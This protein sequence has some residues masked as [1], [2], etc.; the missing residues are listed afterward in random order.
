MSSETTEMDDLELTYRRGFQ[1]VA[2][3][4]GK[5]SSVLWTLPLPFI[6][7]IPILSSSSSDTF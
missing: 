5:L 2:M 4:V 1:F 7:P 6:Q 3:V